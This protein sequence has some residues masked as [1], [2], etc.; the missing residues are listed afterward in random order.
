[1]SAPVGPPDVSH[2]TPQYI[3][4]TNAPALLAKAGSIFGIAAS[5]VLLRIYVRVRIVKSFGH[6]DW[7]IILAIVRKSFLP[8]LARADCY[9]SSLP[10][11]S[12]VMC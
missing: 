3:A 1:M 6:D 12:F 5:I 10:A 11:R 8:L 4:F 7:A 2:L 9:S